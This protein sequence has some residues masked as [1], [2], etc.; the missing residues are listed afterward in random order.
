MYI[1]EIFTLWVN[2]FHIPVR[3]N[4]SVYMY[5]MIIPN[6]TFAFSM[7]HKILYIRY[8]NRNMKH[9]RPDTKPFL[10]KNTNLAFGH[11]SRTFGNK[12]DKLSE[13]Q[14]Q[15]SKWIHIWFVLTWSKIIQTFGFAFRKPF[16]LNGLSLKKL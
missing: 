4:V 12:I 6:Q 13:G 16:R 14:G 2:F 5:R 11:F 10:F 8:E 9:T 3:H 15:S 1:M 7:H